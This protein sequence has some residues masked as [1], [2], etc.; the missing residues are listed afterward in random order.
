MRT[1]KFLMLLT[2]VGG[3][4]G[5]RA[6]GSTPAPPEPA[7]LAAAAREVATEAPAAAPSA[8]T[9]A[10]IELPPDTEVSFM[11]SPTPVGGLTD[12]GAPELSLPR[13]EALSATGPGPYMIHREPVVASLKPSPPVEGGPPG[14]R[15]VVRH[16][17]GTL[18]ARW[19]LPEGGTIRHVQDAVS[20]D[21]RWLAFFSGDAPDARLA[22]PITTPL[23]IH[24][25][26]LSAG[27]EAFRAPVLGADL[28][29]A[30]RQQ[31]ERL[32]VPPSGIQDAKPWIDR[33]SPEWDWAAQDVVDALMAGIGQVRWSPDGRRLA[34]AGAIDGPSSDVYVLEVEGW[35]ITR[36]SSEPTHVIRLS[37]SPDGRWVLHEGAAFASRA[38]GAAVG[39]ATYV[40]AVEGGND[41]QIWA[42]SGIGPWVST[43]PDAWLGEREAILHSEGHG[44]GICAVVHVDVSTGVT[45]TLVSGIEGHDI[46]VD[47]TSRS[48]A[49]SGRYLGELETGS[50]G[51]IRSGDGEG[52]GIYVYPIDGGAPVRAHPYVC[53]I[54]RWDVPDLPFFRLFGA[55]ACRG[56]GAAFGLDGREEEAIEMPEL[57]SRTS[58]APS[59]RWRVT[60][61][62]AGWRIFDRQGEQQAEHWM[63]VAG[64]PYWNAMESLSWHPDETR[65]YWVAGDG[66][67][68]TTE[69]EIP[70]VGVMTPVSAWQG[71]RRGD[72]PGVDL[73]WLRR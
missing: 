30:L 73:A 54:G 70:E 32:F 21:G 69:T 72:R 37:W 17:D 31:T 33:E 63:I 16:G 71:N 22:E 67:L 34:F 43:W 59:R 19:Y 18:A 55:P 47:P 6:A 25:W 5:C 65:I 53:G 12:P 26:D 2:I 56:A 4:A 9:A 29:D 11:P 20:P 10:P 48:V 49:V 46:E 42:Q 15:L 23:S 58:V 68:W 44:C 57:P 3:V 14:T 61:G 62:R 50:Q 45:R 51:T 24:V 40:S 39:E 36:V 27:R 8:P 41:R 64:M 38:A 13:M 60:F 66:N 35:R 52:D 7:T 1:A 28:R